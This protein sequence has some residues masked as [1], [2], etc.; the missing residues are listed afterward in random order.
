M[1]G[2]WMRPPCSTTTRVLLLHVSS[3]HH[4]CNT[5]RAITVRCQATQAPETHAA[6]PPRF[7]ADTTTTQLARAEAGHLVQLSK[8]EARHATRVL[9]LRDVC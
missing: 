2:L 5:H 6:T 8:E 1:M 9:R 4:H 7:Y 3:Y